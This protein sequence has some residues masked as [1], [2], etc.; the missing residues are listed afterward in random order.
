[1]YSAYTCLFYIVN[2]RYTKT[3]KTWNSPRS[4]LRLKNLEILNFA[5]KSWILWSFV[6]ITWII[7][8]LCSTKKTNNF[9]ILVTYEKILYL[10]KIWP[11]FFYRISTF[12]D[13]R[14]PKIAIFLLVFQAT[15]NLLW[16]ISDIIYFRKRTAPSE[17]RLVIE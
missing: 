14:K 12:Y 6:Q 11:P 3:L 1:M 8:Y 4:F 5:R 7:V 10:C 13:I 9:Y 16:M 2:C 17:E 15:G